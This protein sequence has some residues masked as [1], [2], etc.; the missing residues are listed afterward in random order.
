MPLYLVRPTMLPFQGHLIF[1]RTRVD[2]NGVRREFLWAWA[3][4]P[5]KRF[6]LPK[7][8]LGFRKSSLST[9]LCCVAE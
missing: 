9:V 4:V 2:S 1:K 5:G 8:L 3:G 6:L 7:N